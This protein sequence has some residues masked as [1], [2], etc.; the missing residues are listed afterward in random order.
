MLE[1][2]KLGTWQFLAPQSISP[3]C[4]PYNSLKTFEGQTHIIDPSLLRSVG[5]VFVKHKLHQ[6]FGICL[7][8]RHQELAPGYTMVHSPIPPESYICRSEKVG[9]RQLFPH[10]F[11]LNDQEQ[12]WPFEYSDAPSS[13]PEATFLV[14]SAQLFWKLG[15]QE[16]LGISNITPQ[17]R[18]LFESL[19]TNG[20]GTI[21]TPEVID[22][23]TGSVTTEWAFF[24]EE[25]GISIRALRQCT[26]TEAGH[27]RDDTA[28]CPEAATRRD[29]VTADE[30]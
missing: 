24:E 8:H 2:S 3:E 25:D 21:S 14:E 30:S 22:T 19:L 10:A 29:V 17:R 20:E 9:Q 27:K 7:V 13:M 12:F 4:N 28:S 6:A 15:V 5:E 23:V 11:C 1:R 26:D 18:V 16:V